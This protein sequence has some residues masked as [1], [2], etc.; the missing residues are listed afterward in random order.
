MPFALAKI[1]R[2][3]TPLRTP[4][5][6]LR[7][8][9]RRTLASLVSCLRQSPAVRR[10][11]G[12]TSGKATNACDVHY[13]NPNDSWREIVPTR[14]ARYSLPWINCADNQW[15]FD[16]NRTQTLD[17]IGIAI[18]EHGRAA[19]YQ[20]ERFLNKHGDIIW[21]IGREHWSDFQHHFYDTR[22]YNRY[23]KLP[24][25]IAIVSQS[26]ATG[27]FGHWH[28]DIV[29]Q[30]KLVDQM[31]GVGNVDHWFISHSGKGYQTQTFQEFGIPMNK[32]SPLSENLHLIEADELVVPSLFRHNGLA[33][34]PW[35]LDWL[36]S[37]Y[38]TTIPRR[39]RKLYISRA[40]AA[41]RFIQAD[42]DFET[43]MDGHGFEIV[44]LA[45]LDQN[46]TANL[47]AEADIVVGLSGCGLMNT[48]FCAQGTLLVEI[49]NP[50]ALNSYH[51]FAAMEAGC[52]VGIYFGNDQ[53]IDRSLPM[54]R[55]FDDVHVN[56]QDF[57]QFLKQCE[58]QR[59]ESRLTCKV[60]YTEHRY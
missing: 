4:Y 9:R 15:F 25:R 8:Q 13:H 1:K 23:K 35:T 6:A 48:A 10:T 34:Q 39:V 56:S 16:H 17:N 60:T 38:R 40:D 12:L 24:G 27:N 33:H 29:P 20:R 28:F 30:I 2:A 57:L 37:T 49:V 55:L 52:H 18:I 58:Q 42:V 7:N 32:I 19:C 14:I 31:V 44:Q 5:V 22:L 51:W 41:N 53:K 46:A 47:F 43:F 36:R 26:E 3:L 11:L 59:A 54:N 50:Q 45:G 21:D